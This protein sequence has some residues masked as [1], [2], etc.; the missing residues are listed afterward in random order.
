MCPTNT[1]NQNDVERTVSRIVV[2][3][4]YFGLRE[5]PVWF[6][7][8]LL[9]CAKN[10]TIH[11][12]LFTDCEQPTVNFPNI[13][14][15]R[16]SLQELND[17]A[18][19]KLGFRIQKG[20]MSQMDLRPTYGVIFDEYIIGFDFW[21]HC[22]IDVVWGDIRSFFT[23]DIL[24][25]YDVISP[26][27]NF[28]A[29]HLTLW[30]NRHEINNFF[31]IIPAYRDLLL[32][33]E[34]HGLNEAIISTYLRN[35]PTR[36]EA[37]NPVRIYWKEQ[38]IVRFYRKVTPHGWCWD[39]GKIYD[40]NHRE[41][42]YL[43][44][45]HYKKF[46][47][48]IDFQTSDEPARFKFTNYEILAHRKSIRDYLNQKINKKILNELFEKYVRKSRELLHLFKN[49]VFVKDLF[50]AQGLTSNSINPKDVQCDRKTGN[51]YLMKLELFI[52]KK[53]Y[54]FLQNYY[55]GLQLTNRVGAKFYNQDGKL[56]VNIA[57]LWVYVHDSD[58]VHR[59][60]ELFVDGINN[61][62]FSRPTVV[63]D[64]GMQ[65]G[66]STLYF[67]NQSDVVVVGYEPYHKQIKQALDNIA[68]NTP[69]FSKIKINQ[70]GVSDAKFKSIAILYTKKNIYTK[71]VDDETIQKFEYV[72]VEVEDIVNILQSVV[73]E[74]SGRDIFVKIDCRNPEYHINGVSEYHIINKLYDTGM[75]KFV[76]M[77]VLRWRKQRREHDPN[78]IAQ[79]LS[80]YAFRV[81][82]FAPYNPQEGVLYAV[83]S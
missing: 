5:W 74:Y 23:E 83:R 54:Y 55:C 12:L 78:I 3:G 4:T 46:V 64:I 77:I 60:K 81:F 16:M 70:F 8:F 73:Q 63:V 6:P 25:N 75:L 21:G 31:K 42:I 41:R 68:L 48:G 39:K 61:M 72:E 24:Q 27:K 82:L 10:D 35:P 2:I 76:D 9:S 43:H 40:A 79:Q 59:I 62:V 44:F 1:S 67:A 18:S 22:D 71:N 36:P 57:G 80:D 20:A 65:T 51:L 33:R 38:M 45:H 37:E 17:L 13:R 34:H 52:E 53:Q 49:I 32:S 14:F 66:L 7:A 58:I 15:V 69:L 26:R 29:G 28:I 30:R 47:T 50:W 11:W 19:I 56:L